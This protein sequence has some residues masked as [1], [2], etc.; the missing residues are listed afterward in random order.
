MLTPQ[1]WTIEEKLVIYDKQ[2]KKSLM[3]LKIK[4]MNHLSVNVHTFPIGVSKKNS[5]D[6]IEI[7]KRFVSL[8]EKVFNTIK[9]LLRN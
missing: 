5:L 6:D 2:Y 8:I 4:I 3:H 9:Y 7:N 1:F